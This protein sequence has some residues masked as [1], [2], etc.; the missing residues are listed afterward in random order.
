M[1]LSLYTS[2]VVLDVLGIEDFGIFSVVGGIVVIFGFLN[3]A[4]ASATQ[5]FLAFEMGTGNLEQLT[6]IFGTS[7]T[8]HIFIAIGIFIL[9]ETLGLWLLNNQ[10]NIPEFRIEAANWVYQCTVFA[11]IISVIYV[12]FTAAIISHEKMTVFA[13]VTILES[14]LKLLIV[15]SLDWFAYD[16]LKIY[17]VLILI[18][19]L[20]IGV[21]YSL[22]CV[23][24]FPECRLRLAWDK[25]LF[26]KMSD[27]AGWNLLGVFA[28]ITY[29][30]GVNLILNVFFG[31]AVNAARGIVFQIHGAINGFVTNFQMAVNPQLVKSY[32]AGDRN[33]LYSLIYSSSKYS[34]YILLILS[35]PLLL[36]TEYLLN[37]WLKSVPNYTVIFTQLALIDLLICSISGSLQTTAQATGKVRLYQIIVS[38]ILLLNLPISYLLLTFGFSPP[39][40]F[41]VAIFASLSALFARLIV[42]KHIINFPIQSFLKN[43]LYRII[44]VIFFSSIVPY[45]LSTILNNSLINLVLITMLSVIS[46]ITAT[47]FVGINLAEKKILKLFIE[48]ITFIFNP[49]R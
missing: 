32:A 10:L 23:R 27:F 39:A 37:I 12:P 42:L 47:W 2:R 45:Y 38:G 17:S 24:T 14:I 48:R 13:L 29:N 3:N 18:I 35:L 4:M 31:P 16:K 11:F 1:V 7:F 34:F 30:Q 26:K 49:K 8:L 36:Q 21:F 9:A 28:G 6:N 41:F 20:I 44:V 5:R 25:I 19:S 46:V 43:V 40:T 22:Y 15:I 33:Y